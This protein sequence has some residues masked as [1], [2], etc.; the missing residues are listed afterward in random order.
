MHSPVSESP[1]NLASTSMY[2]QLQLFHFFTLV[3]HIMTLRRKSWMKRR[4]IWK[5]ELRI[6]S[7]HI[8]YFNYF[9]MQKFFTLVVNYLLGREASNDICTHLKRWKE[10]QQMNNRIFL[11]PCWVW[12]QFDVNLCGNL[13]NISNLKNFG[14]NDAVRS[15]LLRSHE[16]RYIHSYIHEYVKKNNYCSRLLL[17]CK[18]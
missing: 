17:T 7:P 11:E 12:S 14:G 6:K 13:S 4:G 8:I 16:C 10:T 18:N 2:L 1:S 15:E 3:Q 9:L 5:A